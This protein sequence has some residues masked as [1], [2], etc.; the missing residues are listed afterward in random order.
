MINPIKGSD[1]RLTKLARLSNVGI[2]D[3]VMVERR[4]GLP[5]RLKIAP[6][7]LKKHELQGRLK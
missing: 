1:A 3:I 4:T 5:K 2:K 6:L 7:K